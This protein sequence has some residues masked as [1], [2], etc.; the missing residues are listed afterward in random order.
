MLLALLI[1]H[2][3]GIHCLPSPKP[4]LSTTTT[5]SSRCTPPPPLPP[6]LLPRARSARCTTSMQPRSRIVP[7][8][9]KKLLEL[10]REI[11]HEAAAIAC[12][13]YKECHDVGYDEYV[14]ME[15]QR[16]INDGAIRGAGL[17]D[18]VELASSNAAY[19]ARIAAAA[20]PPPLPSE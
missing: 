16:A 1:L 10:K 14:S 11:E 15:S 19:A 9:A 6:L 20:T 8:H 2:K 3:Y 17:V 5:V 7:L 4:P 13:A 12:A 18:V